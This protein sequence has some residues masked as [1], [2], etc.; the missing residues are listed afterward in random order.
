MKVLVCMCTNG[1]ASIGGVCFVGDVRHVLLQL[2]NFNLFFKLL[3]SCEIFFKSQLLMHH[4]LFVFKWS[5]YL[6]F[7]SKA[8]DFTVIPFIQCNHLLL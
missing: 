6:C 8:S 5:Y 1:C 4:R 2:V 7:G 3:A